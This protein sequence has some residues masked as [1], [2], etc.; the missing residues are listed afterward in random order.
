MKKIWIFYLLS[1]LTISTFAQTENDVQLK[2]NNSTAHSRV[3]NTKHTGFY[4]IMQASLMMGNGLTINRAPNYYM[5]YDTYN[6]GIV[7]SAYNYSVA[8]NGLLLVPSFTFTAGHRFDEHWAM[9]AGTGI[10][11]FDQN[12]FP[13][14]AEL[15]YTLWDN[16]ISPFFVVKCGYAFGN[17]RSKHYDDLYLNWTPYYVNDAGLRNYGGVMFHP[18]TGIKVPLND[19]TDLMFTAAYRFQ[20]LKTVARKDYENGLFDEWEHNEDI[21]RLSFGVAIMFR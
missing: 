14:F 16:R 6:S 15:R 11:I 7:A 13:L 5:P 2:A 18:E 3:E 21:N 12:L 20:K 19:N 10:E 1:T 9:G 4:S 8:N 17:F